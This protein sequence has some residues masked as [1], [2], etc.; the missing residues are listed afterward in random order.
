MRVSTVL[1][2]AVSIFAA[3]TVAITGDEGVAEMQKLAT[4]TTE[5]NNQLSMVNDET[6][7][8]EG[9]VSETCTFYPNLYD[10]LN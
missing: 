8:S 1:S 4:A 9:Y 2:L 10:D 3:R 7:L 6:G 5:Y